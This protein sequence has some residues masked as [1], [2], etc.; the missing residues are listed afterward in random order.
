MQF[1]EKDIEKRKI[2]FEKRNDDPAYFSNTIYTNFPRLQGRPFELFHMERDKPELKAL[3]LDVDNVVS[4]L[5][6]E[7]LKRS[8]IY[9]KP[10]LGIKI[11][12]GLLISNII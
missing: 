2:M 5:N 10:R 6:C 8:H 11:K 9:V 4:L 1:V 3:P 12:I 7:E